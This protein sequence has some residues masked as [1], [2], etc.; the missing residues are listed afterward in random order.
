MHVRTYS[1]QLTS[2]AKRCGTSQPDDKRQQQ[3]DTL[4]SFGLSLEQATARLV[5]MERAR[6]D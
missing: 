5:A 6:A 2:I 1:R 3:L 4:Q